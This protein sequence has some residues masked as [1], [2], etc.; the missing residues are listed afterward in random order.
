VRVHPGIAKLYTHM[1][2]PTDFGVLFWVKISPNF[3]LKNMISTIQKTFHEKQMTQIRQ[4]A[5][6]KKSKLPE[7]YDEVH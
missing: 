5:K 7:F 2:V 6:E 1:Y 4:N 3:D